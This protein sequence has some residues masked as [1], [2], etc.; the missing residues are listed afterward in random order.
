MGAPGIAIGDASLSGVEFEGTIFVDDSTDGDWIG[1]VFG[2]QDSSNFYLFLGVN[3]KRAWQLKRINSETGPVESILASAIENLESVPGQTEVLWS[4]GDGWIHETSYR[5]S[6]LH[7]PDQDLIRVKLWEA[8][9][10]IVD[11]GDI[12]DEGDQSLKGGRLG[13]YCDSQEK[14]TWSALSYKCA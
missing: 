10:L 4:N 8:G 1:A 5:F 6:I 3:E 14:I 11:T 9:V 2:F 7:N 13:V 12:I